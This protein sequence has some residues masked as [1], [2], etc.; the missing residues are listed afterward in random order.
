MT[1]PTTKQKI[2]EAVELLPPDA[3]IEDAIERLYFLSKVERGL[4]D[5]EA[6][7]LIPHDEVK[8]RLLG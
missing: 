8:R 4:A 7:R 3:T 2:L 5:A 1:P 6:G